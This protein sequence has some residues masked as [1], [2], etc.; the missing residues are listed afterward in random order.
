MYV[1]MVGFICVWKCH[2]FFV[3]TSVLAE[4]RTL[5]REYLRQAIQSMDTAAKSTNAVHT[6]VF[7][8][9]TLVL[10]IVFLIPPIRHQKYAWAVFG[11]LVIVQAISDLRWRLTRTRLRR[12]G[13]QRL[14]YFALQRGV[15]PGLL[16]RW[17]LF[18]NLV[19][20]RCGLVHIM[21]ESDTPSQQLDRFRN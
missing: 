8:L 7:G 3:F 12:N 6:F 9:A 20:T 21:G 4:P 18:R 13:G 17:S 14:V 5:A 10:A 16:L 2:G 15:K 19:S 1:K 11:T